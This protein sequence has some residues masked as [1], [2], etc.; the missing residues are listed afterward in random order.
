M[1]THEQFM[2]KLK[3]KVRPRTLQ[4]ETDGLF[5][6]DAFHADSEVEK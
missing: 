2:D 5:D 3:E 6:D 4:E 1:E